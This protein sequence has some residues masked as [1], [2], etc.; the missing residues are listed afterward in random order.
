MT[1][2]SSQSTRAL[3]TREPEVLN[4]APKQ[5]QQQPQLMVREEIPDLSTVGGPGTTTHV[6]SLK[7]WD[8]LIQLFAKGFQKQSIPKLCRV[9]CFRM[10]FPVLFSV[11]A[12]T[13]PLTAFQLA[14]AHTPEIRENVIS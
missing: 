7:N 5:Q 8:T 3:I 11:W 4:I 9:K 10:S 2:F 1:G 12:H 6:Y 13:V 14:P